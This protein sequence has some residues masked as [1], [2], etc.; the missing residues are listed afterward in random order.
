MAIV[1]TEIG[2]E[3]TVGEDAPSAVDVLIF[4]D[5]VESVVGTLGN[6]TLLCFK[7]DR[8]MAEDTSE[9]T[10]NDTV[11]PPE[12]HLVNAITT[13]IRGHADSDTGEFVDENG[14]TLACERR[15]VSGT[16][17]GAGSE[18]IIT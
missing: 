7:A 17:I 12:L 10:L 18:L 3:F 13:L 8:S 9:A 5:S 1:H 11:D 4:G 15:H 6:M 16:Y 14:G 2:I